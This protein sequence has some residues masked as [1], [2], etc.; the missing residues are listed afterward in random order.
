MKSIG[1]LVF[2]FF[3]SEQTGFGLTEKSAAQKNYLN[4]RVYI[5]AFI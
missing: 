3:R 4:T 5:C 1:K 2:P